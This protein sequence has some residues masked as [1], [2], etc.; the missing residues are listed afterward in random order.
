MKKNSLSP[1]HALGLCAVL[2][3]ALNAHAQ[4]ATTPA[5]QEPLTP[6]QAPIA[7]TTEASTTVA[8]TTAMLSPEQMAMDF[9][10]L[11]T[12]RAYQGNLA[13]VMT[14][15]LGLD[16]SKNADVRMLS[17]MLIREHG[18]ANSELQTIMRAKGLPIPAAPGVMH[19]ATADM[20]RR[21]KARNFDAQFM[22][23]QVEAHENSVV[24]YQQ[25]LAQSQDPQVR[26][27]VTKYLPGIIGHTRMI[28]DIAR[29]VN[30]PGIAE[31][32]LMPPASP[33]AMA[34]MPASGMAGMGTMNNSTGTG[35]ATQ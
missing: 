20:L 6:L 13:E 4:T 14:G 31:R 9:D 35:G 8:P 11:F 24:L 29:K 1:L 12:L 25:A 15:Q 3:P 16:K 30:A 22:A 34:M 5:V 26:G 28:Y 2:V 32:P 33:D 27:Y 18:Q 7:Q 21:T 19:M 10:R 23:A 17:Q